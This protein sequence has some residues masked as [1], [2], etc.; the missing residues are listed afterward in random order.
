MITKEQQVAASVRQRIVDGIWGPGSPLPT[1]TQLEQQ[2]P[3][4]RL[5]LQRAMQRL[6][7]QNFIV[8]RSRQGMSVADRPPHLNRYGILLAYHERHNRFWS[9]ILHDAHELGERTG[10]E[11]VPF[12]NL[13]RANYDE[14]EWERL[15]DD[16]E[17]HCLAGIIIVYK[18]SDSPFH[19]ELAKMDIPMVCLNT[20]L[21]P[22]N[23]QLKL[24]NTMFMDRAFDWFREQGKNRV[25]VISRGLSD[26]PLLGCFDRAISK[27]N[28]FHSPS[29]WRHAV[30][31][32]AQAEPIVELMLSM[33]HDQRPDALLI[34]D[35]NLL[36]PAARAIIK[37]DVQLPDDLAILSHCNWSVP[38]SC[39][40]PFVRLG[41]ET[42][43]IVERAKGIIDAM[44]Q[45]DVD[46]PDRIIPAVFEA[47]LSNNPT[48]P[49]EVLTAAAFVT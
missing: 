16:I 46:M 31:D 14:N 38:T 34:A 20:P 7:Q 40:L 1:F 37:S 35:D 26:C 23:I 27:R 28:D 19:Q 30:Y 32:S 9:A 13:A 2:Y 44:R 43:A 47:E 11:F 22:D 36:E 15:R 24:D 10:C 18:I 5:T 39:P 25:A 6:K 42:K 4:S 29:A 12:R 48:S 41:F 33:P 3:A 21:R 45:E 49:L 17:E 8:T